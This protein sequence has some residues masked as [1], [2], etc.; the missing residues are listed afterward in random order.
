MQQATKPRR[1]KG[2]GAIWEASDRGWFAQ[3]TVDGKRL[4][5]RAI[6]R[7]EAQAKLQEMRTTY[8]LGLGVSGNQKVGDFLESW[9][10][11]QALQVGTDE[12]DMSLNTL[13][14]YR[15]ALTPVINVHGKRMLRALEPEHVERLLLDLA[16][17]GKSRNSVA[18]VRSVLAQA[19]EEAQR[20]GKVHRNV[21]RLTRVPKIK[22][23]AE[24]R[25]LTV[26]QANRLLEV[27][28]DTEVEAFILTG[29]MLGL[30]PG[31]LLGLRW[32]D[33]DLDGGALSVTGA[34]K[35][36]GSTIR[37]GDVKTKG[38]RRRLDLAPELIAV[39]RA[40]HK[41]QTEQRLLVGP[42]WQ[43]NGLV[44]AT[45]I[46]TPISP[47]NMNRRLA[48]VTEQAGIGHWSM[49]ELSRHSAASL[50][51][52]E[53]VPLE[54]IADV[55]GHNSTK[56]LEQHYRHRVKDSIDDHVDVMRGV[57]FGEESRRPKYAE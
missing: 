6:T 2:D 35:R 17:Q 8:G 51:Y 1:P 33:V 9:L 57:L 50:M 39:L 15:W 23:S 49:T 14:N 41:L 25:S 47:S 36:E 5:R 40:H 28:K 19:L 54:R 44:F 13:I 3:L 55:L 27:A 24:K 16:T 53:G 20:R 18:R 26:E 43:D 52:A 32:E 37:L 21:A 11:S 31:E 48:K 22:R 46:G 10:Q 4:R 34:L 38:S 42:E 12:G 30:R 29:L 45:E 7:K 56:M